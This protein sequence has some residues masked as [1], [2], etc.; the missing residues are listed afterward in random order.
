MFLEKQ[1]LPD[2]SQK[3]MLVDLVCRLL[4]RYQFAL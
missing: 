1:H 2:V 3:L 4:I